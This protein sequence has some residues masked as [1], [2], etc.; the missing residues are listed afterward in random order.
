MSVFKGSRGVR[1]V[2]DSIR[3]C[4]G[5]MEE[6]G[7]SASP[8]SRVRASDRVL[9]QVQVEEAKPNN[10]QEVLTLQKTNMEPE[11]GP[12]FDNRSL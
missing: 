8:L 12:F 4:A 3:K 2:Q 9:A 5:G 7:T 10:E 6:G 1:G 11:K